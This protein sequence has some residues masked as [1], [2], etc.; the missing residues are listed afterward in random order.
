MFSGTYHAQPRKKSPMAF[1]RHTKLK[2]CCGTCQAY[3]EESALWHLPDISAKCPVALPRK[4]RMRV[5]YGTC[6]AYQD[7]VNCPVTLNRHTKMKMSDDTYQA[8]Q[9]ENVR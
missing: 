9:D 4:T 3:Q 1:N 8:Y 6:K 2:V 7:T 5:A